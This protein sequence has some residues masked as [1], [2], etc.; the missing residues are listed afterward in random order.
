MKT[1]ESDKKF[2]S[3]EN[4]RSRGVAQHLPSVGKCGVL[5]WE[6]S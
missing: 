4:S 6:N 2:D 5:G 3:D 1:K